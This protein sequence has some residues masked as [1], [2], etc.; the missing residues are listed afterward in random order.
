MGSQATVIVLNWN[1]HDYL[2]ECLRSLFAQT[3]LEVRV[4]V[5]DNASPDESWRIVDDEFPEAAL[6]RLPENLHFARG[7]NAGFARALEDPRSAFIIALNND[8]RVDPEW[9]SSL[10]AA[11]EDPHVG[12]VASKMLFMDRPR[13]LNSTGIVIARDGSS[14]D[15]S[16]NVPDE[17]QW[18]AH[19]D[20]FGPSGGAA[21]YRRQLL[22]GV[23]LFDEDFVAYYEDVDLAWRARLAGW[24]SRFAPGA[25]VYHKYSGSMAHRS[26]WRQY[27]CERNRV[28][29]LVQNYPWRY[30]AMGIPW[31]TLRLAATKFPGRPV[32]G[33][34]GAPGENAGR[35]M[36]VHA[37]ARLDAYARIGTA[38]RTRRL[39]SAARIASAAEVGRWLRRYGPPFR[40]ILEG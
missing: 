11:A 5:V 2:R 30:V 25:V 31:N 3:Y 1:G 36:K 35:S 40:R 20:V 7:M 9:L 6:L 27:Q 23:G 33:A 22:E 17:G 21:L 37:R 24:Q 34:D 10:V 18:D 29:N 15:R 38:L 32:A 4:L 13:Y 28:W 16:W 8:V 12:M 19:A 14:M 26:P 39:R